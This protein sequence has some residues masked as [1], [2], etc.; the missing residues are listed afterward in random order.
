MR[1]S[2]LETFRCDMNRFYSVLSC[3]RPS[4]CATWDKLPRRFARLKE[5]LDEASPGQLFYA[6][7]HLEDNAVF[8][9]REP[10]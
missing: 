10:G 9:R 3:S 8:Q 4:V 1:I 2:D 6:R 7:N 5:S